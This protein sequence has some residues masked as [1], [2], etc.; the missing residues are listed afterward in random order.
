MQV[1]AVLD[2]W[3]KQISN[4]TDQLPLKRTCKAAEKAIKGY[5]RQNLGERPFIILHHSSGIHPCLQAADYCMWAV[6]RKWQSGDLRSYRLIEPFIRS[7]YD[8][9]QN[10]REHFY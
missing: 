1:R 4:A 10:G 2:A 3:K 8:I 7:E 9:F 6:Y 5:I